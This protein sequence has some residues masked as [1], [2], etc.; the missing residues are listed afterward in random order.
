[1]LITIALF[2]LV[3]STP[4][5]VFVEWFIKVAPLL[6]ALGL[7]HAAASAGRQIWAKVK[8]G[9][10]ASPTKIDDFL[11]HI[12][13]PPI[14]IALD[15]LDKGDIEGAKQKMQALKDLVPKR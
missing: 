11:V 3:A 14:T 15:L 9:A 2:A 5:D 4:V 7:F 10:A 1:M 13:D 8:D 12:A 6:L